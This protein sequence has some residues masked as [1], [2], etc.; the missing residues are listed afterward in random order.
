MEKGAWQ[1]PISSSFGQHFIFISERI[2]GV[3]PP[4]DTVRTAVRREWANE[5]RLEAERKLYVSLR[6]RYEIVVETPTAKAA[7]AENSR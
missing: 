4:L 5:K 1:G 6:Q 3:L 2:P 7:S